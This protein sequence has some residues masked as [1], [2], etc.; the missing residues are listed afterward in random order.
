MKIALAQLKSVNDIQKNL[1]QIEDLIL[2]CETLS[3]V[4][5]PKIIIFPENSL[6]FRIDDG[7]SVQAQNLQSKVFKNLQALSDRSKIYLHLTTAIKQNQKT[8]NASVLIS[9]DK[10]EV[11]VVYKKIHLFDIALVGQKP[12]CESDVFSAGTEPTLFEIDGVKFGSS[13][14]YDIRF[15]ELY[16]FYA[17]SEADVILIPAAFLVKTGMAHWDILLRARAIESQAYVLA[18]AQAG[19]HQSVV[20]GQCRDTF[21]N[22]LAVDPWGGVMGRLISEVGLLFIDIDI[23]KCRDVRRQIPMRNHRKL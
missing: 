4:E 16:S 9:P 15:S 7:E 1:I 22:T 6:F 20:S 2:K 3:D 19:Q 10:N 11:Q 23:E 17:K 21:G 18:P 12:I 13:I 8:W 14:C 5:K